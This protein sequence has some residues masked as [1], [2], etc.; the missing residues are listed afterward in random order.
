[1]ARPDVRI[2]DCKV[3]AGVLHRNIPNMAG[4]ISRNGSLSGW[5]QSGCQTIV[6][7]VVSNGGRV[8]LH[9]ERR[10]LPRYRESL[11]RR[12]DKKTGP[13]KSSEPVCVDDESGGGEVSAAIEP[14]P[15][16]LHSETNGPAPSAASR[17]IP[18]PPKDMHPLLGGPRGG[19]SRAQSPLELRVKYLPGDG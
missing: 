13:G 6:I 4:Q 12:C 9:V 17:T 19:I 10:R 5:R 15:H 18:R 8:G 1:V 7:P 11:G 2:G 16:G 3:K 14:L